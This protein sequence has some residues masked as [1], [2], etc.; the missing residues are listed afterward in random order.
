MTGPARTAGH[1]PGPAPAATA[2]QGPRHR[3][4]TP[5][6]RRCPP[7][8]YAHVGAGAP[9][10]AAGSPRVDTAAAEAIDGRPRRPD[11][12]S[13]PSGCT[14]PRTGST[15]SCS[16]TRS[17]S[18]ARSSPSWW[19]RPRSRPAQAADAVVVTYDEQPHDSELTR[20]PR[21]PLHAGRD[22][23]RV[24]DRHV[25]RAT[26]PRRWPPPRSPSSAPTRRRCTTTTRWNR[27]PRRRCGTRPPTAADA[28]G[29][30]PGRAPDAGDG[31]RGAR[32]RAG[33]GP[34]R[35]PVRRR[36]L[37]LQGRAA[38][39]PDAGRDGRSRAARPAGEARA[40]PPADVLPDRLPHPDHP[41]GA[42]RRRPRPDG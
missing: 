37:R 33:A 35:L 29:L 34:G 32:P 15:P 28:V 41:T 2:S 19:P 27:T 12:R 8:R 18:A 6:R 13:T 16:P 24:G 4:R 17:P 22:G 39:Q 3:A 23:Q 14:P 42:A 9:S 5:T 25:G 7:R 40:H 38:R 30:H 26:S 20:R 36:R 21:R 10:R 11:A 31:V 1:R